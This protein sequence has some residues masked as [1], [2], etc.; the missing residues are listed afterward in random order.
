MT[1]RPPTP[2]DDSGAP[3]RPLLARLQRL[4]LAIEQ[5]P[6]AVLITDTDG[7]IEYV[8]RRFTEMSG[9]TAAEVMG[10]TPR[11]LKSGLTPPSVYQQLWT[12]ISA[13]QAWRG[14]LCNRRKDGS[15]YWHSAS[16][17]PVRM[18]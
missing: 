18:L 6:A 17:S 4:T 15:L 2:P 16:I 8:N 3:T 11:L 5:S 12:T 9:Y 1:D 10:Q 14:E 13:G 7:R